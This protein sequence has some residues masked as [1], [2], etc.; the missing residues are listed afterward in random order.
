MDRFVER[1]ALPTA[2]LERCEVFMLRWF[3]AWLSAADD[4]IRRSGHIVQDHP[5][6]AVCWADVPGSS[7][8]VS[9]YLVAWQQYWQQPEACG[10]CRRT[11]VCSSGDLSPCPD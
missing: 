10:G 1:R 9:C 5:S 8:L 6:L 2:Q 11:N 3:P 7:A 4:L